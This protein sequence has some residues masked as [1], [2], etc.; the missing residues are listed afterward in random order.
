MLNKVK[1]ILSVILCIVLIFGSAPL[2]GFV[3]IE[4]PSFCELFKFK[5]RAEESTNIEE[6][7]G[8][9]VNTSGVYDSGTGWTLYN[10]GELVITEN[11][12]TRFKTW[13]SQTDLFLPW[14]TLTYE[15]SL[16]ST[17]LDYGWEYYTSDNIKQ[18]QRVTVCDG[19]TSIPDGLFIYHTNLISVTFPSTITSL[20]AGLFDGCTSLES[21]NIE[22]G[23][24]TLSNYT[25]GSSGSYQTT[26][27]MFRNCSSLKSIKVNEKIEDIPDSCFYGCSSLT[28]VI[29]PENIQYSSIGSAAFEKCS[30]LEKIFIPNTVTT[31]ENRAFK[32]CTRLK[33]IDI[34][35]SVTTLGGEVFYQCTGLN[36]V[37]IGSGVSKISGFSG[38]INLENVQIKSGSLIEISSN[39]FSNCVKLKQISVPASLT[40]VVS[41]AF[42]ECVSLH[43]VVYEGTEEQWSA[44]T[45]T[46]S[47]NEYLL[48]AN[49]YHNHWHDENTETYLINYVAT[50]CES[51]GYTG[52]LC[53]THC[54]WLFRKGEHQAALGHNYQ[55]TVVDATCTGNG[56]K[57]TI[58]QNCG[59]SSLDGVYPATGH[60]YNSKI[61][62]PTCTDGGYTLNVCSKCGLST[63]T[64][65]TEPLGHDYVATVIEAT[66]TR[67]GYTVHRCSRCNASYIDGENPAFGHTYV[68]TEVKSTCTG[69]GYTSHKCSTCGDEY[70]T[71]EIPAKGHNYEP[72]VVN[73]SCTT[74]GYTFYICSD[75]G[76]AY[77][78]DEIAATGH[79]Y[80]DTVIAATCTE[81]G[82]T[83]HECSLCGDTYIDN[84]TDRIGHSYTETVVEATC[85]NDGYTRHEC[86]N[87]HD[88]YDTD[89]VS[90]KGHNLKS[91]VVA[92]TCTSGGFTVYSC[93][94][95]GYSSISDET[96]A[97]GH[98]YQPSIVIQQT[99]IQDGCTINICT[100]CSGVSKTDVNPATG[101][102]FGNWKIVEHA[103]EEYEGLEQRHCENCGYTEDKLISIVN[104]TTFSVTFKA[105]G[106]TVAV[107]EYVKGATSIEEPPVPHKDR[108]EGRWSSYNLNDEDITVDA[109]YD[110]IDV[111]SLSGID[112]GKSATYNAS[113]GVATI[114]LYAASEAKTVISTTSEKV[115][116]DIV[117]VVD[118]SGSMDEKLGGSTTKKQALINSATS[119]VNLVYDDASANGVDHRIAIVGFG[120]GNKSSGWDYPAYFNTE[121][122]TTGGNPVQFNSAT[123]ADYADALMNVAVSGELNTD[124]R[125]AI[126]NIDAKGATAA[127]Y[128]LSM[129]NNIFANNTD[130]NGRERIVVFMTDGEPTYSNG[131]SKDVANAAILHAN[132]LKNTYN[133]TVYSIGVMSQSDSSDANTNRFL[134]YVSSNYSD[135]VSVTGLYHQQSS[136]YYLNVTNTNALSGIFEEIVI[137]NITRTT[138][139][140]NITLIDTVSKHFTLTSQ[141]EKALRVNAVQNY[142]VRNSDITVTRNDDGTTLIIIENIHP[143]DDGEKFVV[144]ISFEVSADEDTATAGVYPTNTSDAGIIIGDAEIYECVFTTPYITVPADRATAVFKVNDEIYAI[145]SIAKGETVTTPETDFDG[146]YEFSG[147]NLTTDAIDDGYAE[148]NS[149]YA[150]RSCVVIWNTDAGTVREEYNPGDVINVPDVSENSRGES[151]RR[152]NKTVPVTMPAES[153]EFT[154]VYGDHEHNYVAETVTAMT[155]LSDGLVKYTCSVC[156]DSYTETVDC[157]GEHSWKVVASVAGDEANY[158]TL[159]CENCGESEERKL[160]YTFVEEDENDRGYK[161]HVKHDFNL[162]DDEGN[163]HQPE[164][165]INI[166]MPVDEHYGNV[167][168]MNVYRVD[169]NGERIECKSDY[170]NGVVSFDAD[171]FSTYIFVP[172]H[173]CSIND[174]HID[175]DENNYCDTCDEIIVEMVDVNWVVDGE[176]VLAYSCAPNTETVIPEDPEKEGSVFAGWSPEVPATVTDSDLTFIATW[177][178]EEHEC[179][180][181]LV[182]ECDATCTRN[183]HTGNTYC[184][185]CGT[186]MKA[187]ESISKT[188]H[189]YGEWSEWKSSKTNYSSRYR[190]C[191]TCGNRD[192][193]TKY[194]GGSRK[195]ITLQDFINMIF[196]KIFTVLFGW[197]GIDF[198]TKFN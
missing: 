169:E 176:T 71:N 82:H 109:I 23:M 170:D 197:T 86:Q 30:S 34:P 78:G 145:K 96:S 56:F 29:M 53:C 91:A 54:G 196:T 174:N 98:N 124:I 180:G 155:C 24:L 84:E 93:S 183:G 65:E 117:L 59:K 116:L 36:N 177:E 161:E 6:Y 152:W 143:V 48:A 120:M 43:T 95:C 140:D 41:L 172:V 191:E 130:N 33:I 102:S 75:C 100:N 195:Y 181:V 129:A 66:C 165:D 178:T 76:L 184:S 126:N 111:D 18:I 62:R 103:T 136:D 25:V 10:D 44:I 49:R 47:G 101:H 151:F 31:I 97:I 70:I 80:K 26:T 138:D 99:C 14:N 58:C 119:F 81:G 74:A 163:H 2:A 42:N 51:A 146:E 9:I 22:S 147:W 128:G 15:G 159:E 121:I 8:G 114:N 19:V 110:V 61:T 166:S 20:G 160:E 164:S 46:T 154:A 135:S 27:K 52:D 186:L 13:A 171:H 167:F 115:P 168:D 94:V 133:A 193:E 69:V 123:S 118:Q 142:G 28:E 35:D 122:L 198:S 137:E 77:K 192:V 64:D 37:I 141:Q 21:V 4:L 3:G 90:S 156:G 158:E 157:Y 63:I 179:T 190:D 60:T 131:F 150:T 189:S 85:D 144:D 16:A 188:G 89:V 92:P 67:D 12:S 57:Y 112:Y 106:E 125:K 194:V 105:D 73:P 173:F 139:F 104:R 45:I 39:A 175:T 7:P 17:T 107:V 127:D 83:V 72:V 79:K 162:V 108:F 185:V 68:D 134:N 38:C 187:G 132:E 87:C 40:N 88:Y 11:L 50:T 55:E 32:N 153:I 182:G 149:T 1:K 148:F 113:T 5:A